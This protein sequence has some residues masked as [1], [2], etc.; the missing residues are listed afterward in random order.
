L[1]CRFE[2]LLPDLAKGDGKFVRMHGRRAGSRK[3][4]LQSERKLK[5]IRDPASREMRS[6]FDQPRPA[7]RLFSKA[8]AGYG[9]LT[10]IKALAVSPA[11]PTTSAEAV[12]KTDNSRAGRGKH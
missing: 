1:Q 12:K 11:V 2:T 7:L 6:E 5:S 8:Q 10:L 4:M 3:Q 9:A